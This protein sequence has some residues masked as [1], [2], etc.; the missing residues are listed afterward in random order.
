MD[1]QI[2]DVGEKVLLLIKAFENNTTPIKRPKVEDKDIQF[3]VDT[4]CLWLQRARLPEPKRDSTKEC[5]RLMDE[6]LGASG[7]ERK[8]LGIDQEENKLFDGILSGQITRID[9]AQRPNIERF[10]V[11]DLS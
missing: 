3:Q 5:I 1:I 9:Q 11:F 10:K 7:F 8:D 6:F 4:A 2:F